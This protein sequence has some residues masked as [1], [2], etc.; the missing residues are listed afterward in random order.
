M[1]QNGEAIRAIR[2]AKGIKLVDLAQRVGVTE[3][4]MCHVEKNRRHASQQ[5]L[6]KAAEE[7]AVPV[8]AIMRGLI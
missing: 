3:S 7:M 1:K 2:K 6:N 4:H 8:E 5:L